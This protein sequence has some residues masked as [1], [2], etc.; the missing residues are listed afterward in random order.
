M[1]ATKKCT[2]T[3]FMI[4][5]QDESQRS[6]DTKT[7]KL[8]SSKLA[9]TN[10]L[11]LPVTGQQHIWKEKMRQMLSQPGEQRQV[12]GMGMSISW[13][14]LKWGLYMYDVCQ[15]ILMWL[16]QNNG[17]IGLTNIPHIYIYICSIAI[18]FLN[19]QAVY[20]SLESLLAL[21]HASFEGC[22]LRWAKC[23]V[24]FCWKH[25]NRP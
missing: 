1:P 11:V 15:L 7:L 9:R 6:L 18:K 21:L 2:K 17:A 24:I 5:K 19:F 12:T 22:S 3:A 10:S 20:V 25:S 4:T 14:G 8:Y 16:Q 23:C 13:Y